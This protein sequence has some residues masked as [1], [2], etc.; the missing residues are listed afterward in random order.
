MLVILITMNDFPKV[1][2]KL[3]FK[4]AQKHFWFTDIIANAKALTLGGIYTIKS[5][6]VASSWVKIKLVETGDLVFSLSFFDEV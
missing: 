3:K 1:G 2:A 5:V 4:G 6:D